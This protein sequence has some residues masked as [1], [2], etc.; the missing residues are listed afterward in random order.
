MWDV[1]LRSST[2]LIARFY[3]SYLKGGVTKARAFAEAQRTIYQSGDAWRHPYHW[4]A[5]KLTGV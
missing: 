2:E 1:D 3:E 4:A 5:F